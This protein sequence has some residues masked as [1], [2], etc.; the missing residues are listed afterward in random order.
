MWYTDEEKL[1]KVSVEKIL[2]SH[3][4]FSAFASAPSAQNNSIDSYLYLL[5]T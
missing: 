1:K 2:I 5:D 4:E 3:T